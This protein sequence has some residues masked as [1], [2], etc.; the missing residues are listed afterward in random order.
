[1]DKTVCRIR[2]PAKGQKVGFEPAPAK[3][4]EHPRMMEMV[5]AAREKLVGEKYSGLTA[6]RP[7][8]AHARQ[9]CL[10]GYADWRYLTAAAHL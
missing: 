9:C 10:E 7:V 2:L 6:D 3:L 1:M 8:Q 4:D 5:R